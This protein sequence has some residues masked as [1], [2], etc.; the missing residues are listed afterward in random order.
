LTARAAACRRFLARPTH[1]LSEAQ[2]AEIAAE[3]HRILEDAAFGPLF[4]PG[5]R[6]EVMVV[7]E[8]RGADGAVEVLSGRIDRLLV[9][10]SS[11]LIVDYKT[12]RPPPVTP[13][14]VPA[15]Y[16]R[17]M[18]CYRA[19]LSRIYPEKPITC[20]LLWTDGPRL[21]PLPAEQLDRYLP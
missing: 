9:T 19:A 12:N 10:D 6:A 16:Q 7:G 4:G 18:A 2:Q 17:Q 20:V 3:V 21:M 1:E 11:V 13:A 8:V 5:S 15:I 14:E